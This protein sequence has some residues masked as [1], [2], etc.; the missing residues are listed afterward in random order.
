MNVLMT[1]RLC[2]YPMCVVFLCFDVLQMRSH[3][4]SLDYCSLGKSSSGVEVVKNHHLLIMNFQP[5]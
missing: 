4:F 2:R 3:E 1:D 5:V